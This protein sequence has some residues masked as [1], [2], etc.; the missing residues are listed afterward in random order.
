MEIIYCKT[1]R[2]LSQTQIELAD[3]VL[4]PYRGCQI[5][6]AY[7][8]ARSNKSIGK[9]KKSWGEFVFVKENFIEVLEK[10]LDGLHKPPRRVLIG[11]TTEAFQPVETEHRLTA[12][13]LAIMKNRNI[14]V[15]ILTKSSDI[16][17]FAGDLNYSSE[18]RIYITINSPIIGEKLEKRS[19][20]YE[21]R[22]EAAEKLTRAGVKVV[23]YVSPVIPE[24]TDFRE[25]F[26]WA[27]EKAPAL[28]FE[29]YNPKLGQWHEV[30]GLLNRD[31]F[32]V[33]QEIYGSES[34]YQEY[35]KAFESEVREHNKKFGFEL[36]F[37]IYPFDS[38][39]NS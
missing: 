37:F 3:Y 8:Y 5:G 11:S 4:N 7:C 34:S 24:L 29:S 17:Q 33:F 9:L 1:E 32:G 10:E 22:L 6:C 36:D 27:K 25:L 30:K 28:Y 39:Y 38:Y 23:L 14:P 35:W 19:H 12:Q 18:N 13:T 15:V 26:S 20:S 31:D 16:G 21:R 2:A